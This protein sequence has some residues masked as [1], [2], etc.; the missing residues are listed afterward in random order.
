MASKKNQ[1]G[2]GGKYGA[3]QLRMKDGKTTFDDRAGKKSS[4]SLGRWGILI[5]LALTSLVSLALFLKQRFVGGIS[6]PKI[7]GAERIT[8]TK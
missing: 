7:G 1:G 2:D 4:D 5:L 3:R 6:L 8:F